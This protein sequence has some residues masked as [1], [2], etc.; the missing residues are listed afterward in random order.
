MPSPY[1]LILTTC[2]A[3]EEAE[4]IA[5]RLVEQRLAGCVQIFAVDSV[6]RW[7]G[8]VERAKEWMLFCKIKASDFGAVE[9]AIR[10][11]HSYAT[12]EIIAIEIETGAK[13][14]LAWLE[15]AT[16]RG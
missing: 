2:G 5:S 14:Y 11:A 3:K 13:A 12:P 4:R 6:Y 1:S 15:A 7:E 8:A 16:H 9:A 10:E